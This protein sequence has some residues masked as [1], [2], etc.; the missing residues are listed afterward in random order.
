MAGHLGARHVHD[1]FLRV[2]HQAHALLHALRHH[3]ARDQ[4][5]VGVECLDPIVVD[6]AGLLGVDLAD[7]H[8]RSAARQRQHQQVVG[9]GGVD[10]P[11]LMRRDE[12]EHDRVIA[13]RLAVDD[14][15]D[16]FGIDRRTIDA[17]ALA[18]RAHP[19]MIL[20]EL[21]AAGQR[22]PGDQFVHVGVA[23]VVA[24]LLRL[25]SRPDWRGDDLARLRDDVAEAD[26]LVFLRDGEMAVVTPGEAAERFPGLDRDLAIGLRREAE[27]HLAG[28][29]VA[30]DPRQA[31]ARALLGDG[32]VEPLE[33]VDLMLG[34][35]AHAL[36]AIAELGHQRSERGEAFVEV[37]IV[38]LDHA[39]PPAWFCRGSDRSRLSS[40]P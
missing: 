4:R 26:F 29:D 22:A 13:V 5:A 14:R 10:A 11:L 31:L 21:L 39:R 35:P 7:P 19:Q 20:I 25:Q 32:A 16:R 40:S 33:E 36:A 15:I 28:I 27:D 18:E 24:D 37:G 12:V 17:E 30:F 1:L 23:G 8:A 34:I 2:I 9:I 3:R 38:A 6:D